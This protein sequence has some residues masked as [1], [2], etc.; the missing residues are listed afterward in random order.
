MKSSFGLLVL[1]SLA[2]AA[3]GCAGRSA[4][5][6]VA[7]AS[8]SPVPTAAS[9]I[10]AV[11]FSPSGD[12]LWF[13]RRTGG[14]CRLEQLGLAEREATVIRTLPFCP[15][16]MS[17]A[18][19]DLLVR[20]PEG[21]MLLVPANGAPG[22]ATPQGDLVAAADRGD[23]VSRD[24]GGVLW[25]D[26]HDAR[27]RLAD[28]L[29]TRDLRVLADPEA[30]VGVQR[31][32]EGERLVRV[33]AGRLIPLSEFYPA[34]DSFGLSPENRELV[35]SARRGGSF[36]VAI[37][38]MTG[39]LETHW[40][41]PDP[42]DE[43]AVSW[44]PRGNKI[45]YRLNTPI[46]ALIRT[47][48]VST[49]FAVVAQFPGS[50]V[51]RPVWEPRGER[52]AVILS[53]IGSSSHVDWIR[54]DGENRGT[55]VPADTTLPVNPEP[56]GTRQP[57]AL[58]LP[59][60]VVRYGSRYPLILWVDAGDPFR[61]NDARAQ[62]LENRET[63]MILV[64]GPVEDLGAPFWKAVEDLPW[65]DSERTVLVIPRVASARDLSA[66]GGHVS[67]VLTGQ[68]ELGRD[69]EGLTGGTRMH[70]FTATSRDRIES[71]AAGWIAQTMGKASTNG[72]D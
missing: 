34:I 51:S 49:S 28:N 68:S 42:A 57:G 60:A 46:G 59:P 13:S 41:P 44:A 43:T 35:Y 39:S 26:H 9:V 21:A 3:G 36:D 14:S 22:V 33:E 29:R 32:P 4:L 40:V 47:V 58:V 15:E 45:T 1:L 7:P 61:W 56:L 63:G 18:G 23:F 71:L 52:F 30:V 72:R 8:S 20:G 11:V 65:A 55:L 69:P 12:T 62:V 31:T 6:H 66:V 48:H 24:S 64:P 10:S 50:E 19:E 5:D 16:S 37:T 2:L 70:R 25:W 17:F 67:T 53:S 38:S 54:Y 27:E